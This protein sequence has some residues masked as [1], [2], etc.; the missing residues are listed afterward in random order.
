VHGRAWDAGHFDE[1]VEL[2]DSFENVSLMDLVHRLT[3]KDADRRAASA[4]EAAQLGTSLPAD[5][6][7]MLAQ[8]LTTLAREESVE[9]TR[10]AQTTAAISLRRQT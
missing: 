7:R 3:S 5:D 1:E 9:V 8:L 10:L 6:Q 4:A 2:S